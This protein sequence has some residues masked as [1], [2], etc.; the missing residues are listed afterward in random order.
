M[1][2][3]IDTHELPDNYI[4]AVHHK[5][6][7]AIQASSYV[8]GLVQ[9]S[10]FNKCLSIKQPCIVA[11]LRAPVDVVALCIWLEFIFSHE[12]VMQNSGCAD[13]IVNSDAGKVRSGGTYLPACGIEDRIMVPTEQL[14]LPTFLEES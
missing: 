14:P 2:E 6:L 4:G 5:C 3:W 7:D 12:I 13:T 1:N 8:D 10:I 11:L 9:C